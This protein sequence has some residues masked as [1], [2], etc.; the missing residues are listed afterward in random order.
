MAS[1]EEIYGTQSGYRLPSSP[2]DTQY[3]GTI[4]AQGISQLPYLY[5]AL[6]QQKAEQAKQDELLG[7]KQDRKSVV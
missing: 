7:L 4:L 5:L 3:P 2:L 6:Q 1:L